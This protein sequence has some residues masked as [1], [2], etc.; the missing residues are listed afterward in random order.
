MSNFGANNVTLVN[1]T[2]GTFAAVD[3]D[4]YTLVVTPVADGVVAAS[5]STNAAVDAVGNGSQAA[6][7]AITSDRTPP[8]LVI[9]P[10]G[11]TTNV[12][13]TTF[14]FQFR[15]D[16][17]GFD[18]SDITVINGT[19]GTFTAVDANTYTLVVAATVDGLVSIT[20]NSGVANDA[21]GNLNTAATASITSDRTAP[22]LTISPDGTLTNAGLI[23]F[24]FQF[25]EAV[26]GFA[27][28]DIQVTN[29][30]P[31][32][33]TIVDADTYTLAV[34]PTADGDL[35]VNVAANAASDLAA[36][37]NNAATATVTSDRTAPIFSPPSEVEVAENETTVLN[38]IAN[39]AHGP[40]V[41]SITGGTDSSKFAIDSTT[42]AL[43]FITAPD[44]ENPADA[45][46]N[47]SYNVQVSAVD[48]VN[49]V[50]VQT[51]AVTVTAVNDNAPQFATGAN[52]QD[53]ENSTAV[54]TVSATDADK[55]TQTV[56]FI[57]SGGADAALFT[58]TGGGA[59]AFKVAPDFETPVDA[60]ANNV[61]E[62]QVT[63]DDG[64]GLTSTQSLTITVT[65]AAEAPQVLLNGQEVIW[66]KTRPAQSI[67]LLPGVIVNG[68]GSLAN[69]TLLIS[70]NATGSKKKSKDILTIPSF[71]AIGQSSGLVYSNFQLNLRIDLNAQA[72]AAGVQAL[73]RG[74]TFSTKGKGLKIPT[75]NLHITLSKADG[76]T[77]TATQVIQ[78][79]KKAVVQ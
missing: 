26:S 35:T 14:T 59:L 7:A 17:I 40:V 10:T 31:G 56:T 68:N 62:V 20:V 25:S 28:G 19:K 55:P 38:V 49:Q 18:A 33:F 9:S 42:G 36:N 60:G 1:G 2:K 39:D 23:T 48:A 5:V 30:T 58:I 53:A 41:Y 71:A 78:V 46:L 27:A 21:A 24:T 11:L 57:I 54:G 37:A 16:V 65:D 73:L 63:A 77:G 4:T 76:L 74:I 43:R 61:Y 13:A 44:F 15:E 6:N 72:T 51:L 67:N 32:T 64:A 75:R 22:Q 12:I 50:A 29:G 70:M 66:T 79:H 52:F 8:S 3:G 47:N 69:G 34:T 45:D